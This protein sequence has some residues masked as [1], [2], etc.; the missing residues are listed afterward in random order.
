MVFVYNN[1]R[2]PGIVCVAVLLED[3]PSP[4]DASFHY[5]LVVVLV[6]VVVI[7][8]VIAIGIAIV[9]VVEI[10]LEI[11]VIVDDPRL[12]AAPGPLLPGFRKHINGLGYLRYL[13]YLRLRLYFGLDSLC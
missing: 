12:A 7:V 9:I 4:S 11:V 3:P 2:V 10:E 6:I 1:R 13:R 5:W 8:T